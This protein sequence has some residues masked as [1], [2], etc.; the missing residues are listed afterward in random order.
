MATLN[1]VQ[2]I[3][4][5]L[6]EEMKRDSGV[7]LMGEDVGIQGG[8]FRASED[9]QKTFGEERVIDTPLAESAIVSIAIGAAANGVRPIAEIQFADFAFQAMDQIINEAAR[10][11][12]RSN[13]GW[14][15]PLVIRIPFGGGVHGGLY[16]SQSIEAYF[17][18]VP[19]LKVIVPSTPG[20]T[21]FLLKSAIRDPDPVLFFEHKKLYRSVR[22]EVPDT[23][24]IISIGS[25]R[26]AREGNDISVVTYGLMV[27]L[28]LTA[29]GLV[30]KEGI[31][32]EVIDLRTLAP[33]DKELIFDSV[34][35]TGRVLVL[36][37]DNLTMGFG[38]EVAALLASESF[39]YLD[40][41]VRRLASLDIP[42]F[43]Y[44]QLLE[45]AC[46]PS[47]EMIV[48]ALQQLIA[49]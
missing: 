46:I 19:G 41:P 39:E 49:Y 26:V 22:E 7:I 23:D 1:L 28:A 34:R 29:A 11:R 10:I 9:L 33:L 6:F 16:H 40:A 36:Y 35:K 4:A 14:G 5:A 43:P 21:K 45:E 27:H 12:Y 3:N 42:A 25:G 13:G 37:E 15:C 30:A 48:G 20:D 32:V 47:V 8:V 17:C 2:A 24:D 44:N 38:A 18:H 31:D